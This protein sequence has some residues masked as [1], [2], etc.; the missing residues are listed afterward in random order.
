M[1]IYRILNTLFYE[2]VILVLVKNLLRYFLIKKGFLL[3]KSPFQ[4][5]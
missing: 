5:E 2:N 1:I 3:Q 4:I